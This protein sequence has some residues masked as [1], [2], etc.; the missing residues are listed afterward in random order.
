MKDLEFALAGNK[1]KE[2]KLEL[3]NELIEL[4][5]RAALAKTIYY[6]YAE[7]SA[8]LTAADK[9]AKAQKD[10]TDA[11]NKL[12]DLETKERELA[13]S[14]NGQDAEEEEYENVS[15]TDAFITIKGSAGYNFEKKQLHVLA[16][17]YSFIDHYFYTIRGERSVAGLID[18][19]STRLNSSHRNTSRMPSSA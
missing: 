2:R 10:S 14:E 3:E 17:G 6:G 8:E 4:Q 12:T 18:R 5:R 16:S 15:T 7:A 9:K 11:L 19:K 1:S 13:D